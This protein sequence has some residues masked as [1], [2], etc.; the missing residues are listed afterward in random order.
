MTLV[1]TYVLRFMLPTEL[2]D[3]HLDIK[4]VPLSSTQLMLTCGNKINAK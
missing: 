2:L 1:Q 3:N 4:R